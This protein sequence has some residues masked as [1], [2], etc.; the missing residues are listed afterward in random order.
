MKSKQSRTILTI[1]SI[2][3][4][5][6]LFFFLKTRQNPASNNQESQKK[7]IQAVIDSK[8]TTLRPD[9]LKADIT[10][11]TSTTID[12][13]IREVHNEACGGDPETAPRVAS[14]RI[15]LQ[16]HLPTIEP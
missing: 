6:L 7:V 11:Q 3:I 8:L 13:E 14:V 16:T 15:D 4:I 12:Y 1:I 2:V 9:C 5:V 10:N